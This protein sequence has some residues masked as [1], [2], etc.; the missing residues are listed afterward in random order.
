[1]LAEQLERH[2]ARVDEIVV[3]RSVDADGP[4]TEIATA[5]AASEIDWVTVTS[6]AAARALV[7]FYGDTLRNAELVSIGPLTSAALRAEG[8]EPV[9]EASPQTTDGLVDAILHMRRQTAAG[10]PAGGINRS[11]VNLPVRGA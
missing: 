11:P 7:R 1:V 6:S 3:Y 4:D 9:A 2:G 8:F 5:L 10:A